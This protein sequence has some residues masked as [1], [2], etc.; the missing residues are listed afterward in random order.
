[1]KSKRKNIFSVLLVIVLM[2]GTVGA[3]YALLKNNSSN[4]DTVE[5]II[6]NNRERVSGGNSAPKS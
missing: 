1:M 4:T 2:L 6:E 5:R 3:G